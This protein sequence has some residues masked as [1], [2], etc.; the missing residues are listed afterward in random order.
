MKNIKSKNIKYYDQ[1]SDVFYIGIK[2]GEEQEYA[3]IAPG[4]NVEFDQNGQVIGVEIL[5][6][7]KTLKPVAK[8]IIKIKTTT[9]K[10]VSKKTSRPVFA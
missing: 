8:S 3:E 5:N 10:Q 7:S 4:V 1:E 2:S 6:A 9:S